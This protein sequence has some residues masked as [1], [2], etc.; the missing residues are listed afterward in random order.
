VFTLL[1]SIENMSSSSSS[2]LVSRSDLKQ[3]GHVAGCKCDLCDSVLVNPSPST[4]VM[5]MKFMKATL[6][7]VPAGLISLGKNGGGKK[8]RAKGKS[9]RKG[10]ADLVYN[11]LASRPL[12]RRVL[13]MQ[14]IQ[15]EMTVQQTAFTTSNVATVFYGNYLT[16]ASFS[17]YTEYTALFDQYRIDEIECWIEPFETQSTVQALCGT[18]SSAVDLDDANTPTS[19]GNVESKQ[20][21]IITNG[22]AG[23]YHRWKPHM[24]VAVYSGAFTSFANAPAGWIDSAS[25]GVQHY[26]IK[27]AITATTNATPYSFIGKALVSFRAPGI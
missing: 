25:P 14:V 13:K 5:D 12:L 16:L 7:A 10:I 20:G 8:S 24:A 9:K 18:F 27:A 19:L 23:H 26:G 15:V 2:S 21:C 3:N 4:S 1:V 22:Q 6:S 11:T 17:S